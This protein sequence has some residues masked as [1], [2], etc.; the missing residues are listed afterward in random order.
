MNK[1]NSCWGFLD[2]NLLG[3]RS[4]TVHLGT[5]ELTA[6]TVMDLMDACVTCAGAQI[7]MNNCV[8]LS[9]IASQC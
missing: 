4:A 2:G 9:T 7:G 6:L 1:L 8:V 3:G 5:E